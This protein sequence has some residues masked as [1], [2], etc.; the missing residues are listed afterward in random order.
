MRP[1][2][3]MRS[4]SVDSGQWSSCYKPAKSLAGLCSCPSVLW[5]VDL[6][7]DRTGY[8]AEGISKQ[9]IE[10][11]ACFLLFILKQENTERMRR[12]NC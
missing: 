1:Q 4:K 6:A 10:G 11:A 9:S 3:A 5:K 2:K 7:S 12:K 8:L